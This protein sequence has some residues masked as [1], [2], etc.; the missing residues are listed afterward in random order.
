MRKNKSMEY[1][2]EKYVWVIFI[3]VFILIV[4]VFR[5]DGERYCDLN[6]ISDGQVCTGLQ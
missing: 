2:I 1:F 4:F 5:G 6:D 3:M